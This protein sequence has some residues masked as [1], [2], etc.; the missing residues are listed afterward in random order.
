MAKRKR[1]PRR[2]YIR[3]YKRKRRRIRIPFEMI[4]G[5]LAI[6][7][8][9]PADN[10]SMSPYEWMKAGR[11]DEVV[12]HLVR[13]FTGYNIPDGKIN[14][15]RALNPFDLGEARYWKL[16]LLTGLVGTI[17]SK[18]VKSSSKLFQKVPFIG[19]WVK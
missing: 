15:M 19:R 18:V 4:M 2:R 16:L 14:V 8:S 3:R 11:P 1:K 12:N 9:S 5:A 13:G 10:W 17:R 6:P 7:F